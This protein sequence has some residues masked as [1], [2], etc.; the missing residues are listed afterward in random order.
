MLAIADWI[1]SVDLAVHKAH[2]LLT[3]AG[4]PALPAADRAHAKSVTIT[5]DGVAITIEGPRSHESALIKNILA[6]ISAP[7]PE[8]LQRML[9]EVRR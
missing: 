3:S 1:E 5:G 8:S 7:T 9:D 2:Q 6:A 4:D